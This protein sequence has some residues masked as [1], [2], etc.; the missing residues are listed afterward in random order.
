MARRDSAAKRFCPSLKAT[1]LPLSVNAATGMI[2]VA[3]VIA[4]VV[5]VA[6]ETETGAAVTVAGAVVEVDVTEIEGI[7]LAA[8]NLT[9]GIDRSGW[10]PQTA[11]IVPS[12]QI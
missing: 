9:A 11:E 4:A 1:S 6:G 12:G 3:I 10:N 2:V 5:V 7:A 8:T